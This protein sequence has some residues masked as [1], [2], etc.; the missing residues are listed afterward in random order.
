MKEVAA[1]ALAQWLAVNEPEL[2]AALAARADRTGD[3]SGITD[4]ISSIGSGIA[5][6]ASTVG[7]GLT[8]AVK[9][10]GSFIASKD[11]LSTLASLGGSYLQT[12]AQKNALQVQL[13]QVQAGQPPAPIETRYDP[14]TGSYVPVY[15]PASGVP[16]ALTP[17]LSAQ[18]LRQAGF[19]WGRWAPWLIGGGI[20]FGV[21]VWLLTRDRT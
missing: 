7:S 19:D 2:F 3:L 9:G 15:V 5:K 1:E 13:A 17:D 8:A 6:A 12:Q 20:A 10:V 16:Q 21:V 14:T 18:L 4:I 11:G